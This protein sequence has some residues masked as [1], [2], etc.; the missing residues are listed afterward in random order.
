VGAAVRR[1]R[2]QSR[3][4]RDFVGRMAWLTSYQQLQK[5]LQGN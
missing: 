4:L 1:L 3:D 5:V 2:Q